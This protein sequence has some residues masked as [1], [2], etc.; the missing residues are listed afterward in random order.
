MK[1]AKA[2]PEFTTGADRFRNYALW[3]YRPTVD[4]VGKF[5][6]INLL[7]HSFETAGAHERLFQLT[8]TIRE[9][10]GAS[11]TVWGV[12]QTDAGTRWEFYF[13]DYARSRRERSISLVL[14]A[15]KPYAPS[16]IRQ[17]ESLLY[18]M[19]SLDIDNALATGRRDL[20]EVHM[21][22]GNPGS[23]VSSGI[24][25]SVTPGASRVES[26]YFFFDARKQL[27]E[28]FAKI[29]CSAH[30]DLTRIDVDRIVLPEFKDCRTICVAN[31]QACDC[32]YFAG[33]DVD[34]FISFLRQFGYP[35]RTVSYVQENRSMLDHLEYDVGFDYR[36]DEDG[37]VILKSGYY[38]IF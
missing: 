15:I 14:D 17:N 12:K 27:D 18:F 8:R 23:S 11:N 31:K 1:D 35:D 28:V 26:F 13:Y 25:Y 29:A 22:I 20:E 32:I 24:C 5:R 21:Y 36:M 30:V 7:F 33:I 34:R 10:V 38:G 19:F 37:L 3:S 9:T 2:G 6:S 4:F 16:R